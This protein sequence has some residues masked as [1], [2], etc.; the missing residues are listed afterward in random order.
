MKTP[1]RKMIKDF[2]LGLRKK[3]LAHIRLWHQALS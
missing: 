2:W 1:R 3:F